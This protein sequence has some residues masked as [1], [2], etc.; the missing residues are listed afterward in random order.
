MRMLHRLLSLLIL[1]LIVAC[2]PAAP[3]ETAPAE[4]AGSEPD[5]PSALPTNS[6][7]QAPSTAPTQTP[8]SALEAYP[9]VPT[10][11][12]PSTG[13]YPAQ[14]TIAPVQDP[15]SSAYPAQDGFVWMLRPLGEQCAEPVENAPTNLT[16]AMASL[17]AAGITIGEAETTE[18]VVCSACGCPTSAHFRIQVAV[19]DTTAAE[20]LGWAQE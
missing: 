20:S 11:P 8:P 14:P 7:D 19:N 4:P 9:A 17:T 6:V 18:L 3:E 12:P 15:N 10:P 5:I 1:M 16:E 2:G 13:G